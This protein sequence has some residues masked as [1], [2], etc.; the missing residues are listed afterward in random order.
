M[1][2]LEDLWLQNRTGDNLADFIDAKIHLNLKVNKEDMYW[3]QRARANW[4][5]LSD[6]NTIFFHN[7]ASQRKR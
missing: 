5:K 4:L 1:R 2:R 7:F 3:E 6:K